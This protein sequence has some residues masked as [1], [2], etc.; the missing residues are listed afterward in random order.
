MKTSLSL[1]DWTMGSFWNPGR[2][3]N[4]AHLMPSCEY[5]AQMHL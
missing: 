2:T 3:S 4:E 5:N 1:A